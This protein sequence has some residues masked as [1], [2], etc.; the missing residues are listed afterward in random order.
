[1]TNDLLIV[2]DNER[3]FRSLAIN[4]Q[5]NGF[6]CHWAANNQMAI[7][8]VRN[9]EFA[10]A[11]IDLS[12]GGESGLDVMGNLLR[13]RPGFPVVF[14]S[15]FGTLEAAVAAMKMGAFDFLPKPLDFKRLLEVV[16]YAIA[17]GPRE[18]EEANAVLP[19]QPIS[20]QSPNIVSATPSMEKLLQQAA[21]AADSDIPVLITGESGTG[22]ESIFTP[23]PA[24]PVNP[25]SASIVRPLPILSP[26]PNC[27]AAP[28]GPLPALRVI[29]RGISHRP[30]GVPCISMK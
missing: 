27:S 3:V 19:P 11:I 18:A 28:G 20:E 25:S 22:K 16:R 23:V 9:R 7:D 26:N 17:A 6:P 8:L 10:A 15:G 5:R 29:I 12:L 24:A 2:D 30:T 4:F 21:R 14:I 1:M 13:L